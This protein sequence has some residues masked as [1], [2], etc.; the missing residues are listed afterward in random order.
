[1]SY[2]FEPSRQT[3]NDLFD[4]PTSR[5]IIPKYQREYSWKKQQLEEY[6]KLI[7][8]QDEIFIGTVIFYIEDNKK[9]KEIIDGQ[10]RYITTII[11]SAALRDYFLEKYKLTKDRN[12]EILAEDIH[13][14]YIGKRAPGRSVYQNYLEPGLSTKEYFNKEIQ[15]YNS[16]FLKDNSTEIIKV[17]SKNNSTEESLIIEAY[18]Y[19]KDQWKL[20]LKR[21]TEMQTFD[22][23][24]KRLDN[25]FVIRIEIDNYELAFDIFESVNDQG[26]RLGVSDLL[27]NQ[28]LKNIVNNPTSQKNAVTK[29]NEMINSIS[30]VKISPQEF[31]R[32]YWASK[33]EYV[34]DKQLY[35]KIKKEIQQNSS[36]NWETFLE[37]IV[38]EAEM[39]KN[40]YNYSLTSWMNYF[41]KGKIETQK[42][43]SSIDTFKKM[44]VKTWLI[45]IMSIIRNHEKL[46][47]HKVATIGASL[48]EFAGDI[49][50]ILDAK[51]KNL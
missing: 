1:M 28:I 33:Y 3:L 29:W 13:E 16:D 18:N 17:K 44:K 20:F 42:F 24:K 10:Q 7:D 47:A 27:K 50:S 43:E 39:I 34:S 19:F 9:N 4:T 11:A 36:N 38:N 23:F 48:E 14:G 32:Y 40:I 41:N 12:I 46:T 31:L 5:Y 22:H 51:L 21:N 49:R 26:I 30:E 6:W 8:S 35:K 15:T 45:L 37:T 2:K 25:C